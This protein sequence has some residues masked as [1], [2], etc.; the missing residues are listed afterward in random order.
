MCASHTPLIQTTH[1]QQQQIMTA[2]YLFQDVIHISVDLEVGLLVLLGGLQVDDGQ[3]APVTLR[4]QRVVTT[5]DD[6]Q[7][8]AQTQAHVRLSAITHK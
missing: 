5:R 8:G 4:H 7:G 1:F 3:F 6:L 2:P